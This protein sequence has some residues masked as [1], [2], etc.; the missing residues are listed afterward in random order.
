MESAVE[1][2]VVGVDAAVFLFPTEKLENAGGVA[3]VGSGG[4]VEIAQGFLR[5]FAVD[6]GEEAVQVFFEK[7]RVVDGDAVADNVKGRHEGRCRNCV[8]NQYP[9][10][11][12]GPDEF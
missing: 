9:G 6:T 8:E 3:G 11:R 10:E 1:Q 2:E 12:Y 7:G 4:E 5:T